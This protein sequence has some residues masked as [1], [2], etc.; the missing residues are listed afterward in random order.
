[1][2]S[3]VP[4]KLVNHQFKGTLPGVNPENLAKNDAKL[5]NLDFSKTA[6]SQAESAK[7]GGGFGK[8]KCENSQQRRLKYGQ[9]TGAIPKAT[10]M[11]QYFKVKKIRGITNVWV[12]NVHDLEQCVNIAI[13]C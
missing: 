9:S 13:N 12:C 11:N 2:P 6:W 5:H 3:E 4:P 10:T 8:T 7:D 1:M